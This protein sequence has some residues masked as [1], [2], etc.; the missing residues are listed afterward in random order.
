MM[1][2][3]VL[4]T[5]TPSRTAL[6]IVSGFAPTARKKGS[7][8]DVRITADI[9]AGTPSDKKT[10]PNEWITSGRSFKGTP[11]PALIRPPKQELETHSAESAEQQRPESLHI[12][13][14]FSP[15]GTTPPRTMRGEPAFV[16]PLMRQRA[17]A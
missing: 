10:S 4:P 11:N 15:G 7:S 14:T 2:P 3:R 1:S 5:P 9:A 8:A 6:G 16:K 12:P 13:E 17:V